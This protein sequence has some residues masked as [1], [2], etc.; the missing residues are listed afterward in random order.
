[1]IDIDLL[2]DKG[3]YEFQQLIELFYTL[4]RVFIIFQNVVVLKF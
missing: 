1:M 2:N 4:K 3:K